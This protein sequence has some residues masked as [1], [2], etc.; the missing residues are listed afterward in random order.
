M[1]PIKFFLTILASLAILSSTHAAE[2]VV[3]PSVVTL[4]SLYKKQGET[5]FDC[6]FNLT[7][8]P[9][10][11]KNINGCTNDDDYYFRITNPN[12]GLFFAITDSPDCTGT[13]PWVNYK[14][15]DPEYGSTSPLLRIEAAYN[16]PKGV[17]IAAGIYTA[18]FD[19][20]K[21][22]KLEGKVSCVHVYP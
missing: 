3:D 22:R 9:H 1:T 5:H 16:Q 8:G 7:V 19:S 15:I 11:L 18:G 12:D 17:E 10:N 14:I 4:I 20:K 2:K 21:G 13:G 6:S